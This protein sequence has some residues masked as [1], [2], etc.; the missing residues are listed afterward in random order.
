MARAVL[1]AASA[2]PSVRRMAVYASSWALRAAEPG[3]RG[4]AGALGAVS[5]GQLGS[6]SSGVI[7][8]PTMR[9]GRGTFFILRIV[10]IIL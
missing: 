4:G 2:V 9:F 10:L 3:S 1:A 6:R 8:G 7:W 5:G